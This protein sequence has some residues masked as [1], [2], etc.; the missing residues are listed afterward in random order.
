MPRLETHAFARS[1]LVAVAYMQKG[2]APGAARLLLVVGMAALNI[3]PIARTPS[4]A[5]LN[6]APFD[7]RGTFQLSGG[8]T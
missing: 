8:S 6:N 1:L 3:I 5:S 7:A 2:G 4:A